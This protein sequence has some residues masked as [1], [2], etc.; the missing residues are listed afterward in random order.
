M[1]IEALVTLSNVGKSPARLIKVV[2]NAVTIHEGFVVETY[3]NNFIAQCRLHL[4]GE[5]TSIIFPDSKPEP[6]SLKLI[7]GRDQLRTMAAVVGG[8]ELLWPYLFIGVWYKTAI[9][10][11]IGFSFYTYLVRRGAGIDKSGLAIDEDV[12]RE[13]V[14]ITP[15]DRFGPIA[16]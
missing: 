14:Y 13:M 16:E 2:Q 1:K 9:D 12:P 6:K 7:L 4:E 11:K 15:D 3:R 8:E 10:S 5:Q